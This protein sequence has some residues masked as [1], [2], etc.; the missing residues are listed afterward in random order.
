MTDPKTLGGQT[1]TARRWVSNLVLP[2]QTVALGKGP[3]SLSLSYVGFINKVM[4][5]M[6]GVSSVLSMEDPEYIVIMFLKGI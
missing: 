1:G 4:C 3:C 2:I 5:L 6:F